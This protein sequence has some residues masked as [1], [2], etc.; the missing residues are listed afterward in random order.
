[1][2]VRRR[3]FDTDGIE[4]APLLAGLGVLLLAGAAGCGPSPKEYDVDARAV[5]RSG[6]APLEVELTAEGRLDGQPI[7][8]VD[9]DHIDWVTYEWRDGGTHISDVRAATLEFEEP[10]QHVVSV[11]S[12]VVRS[13]VATGAPDYRDSDKVQVFVE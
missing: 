12:E 9:D 8:E 10:G 7:R 11:E 1:M 3:T 5:P 4:A 13:T 6:P 2:H